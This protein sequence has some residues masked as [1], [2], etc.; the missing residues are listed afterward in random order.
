MAA[1]AAAAT[2]GAGPFSAIMGGFGLLSSFFGA[3]SARKKQERFIK[4]MMADRAA[5]IAEAKGEYD[6]SRRGLQAENRGAMLAAIKGVPA[7]LGASLM[8]GSTAANAMRSI[9]ADAQRRSAEIGRQTAAGKADLAML[10]PYDIVDP[11]TMGQSRG[12]EMQALSG[13]LSGFGQLAG[14]LL[15]RP[16]DPYHGGTVTGYGGQQYKTGFNEGTNSYMSMPTSGVMPGQLGSM[17]WAPGKTLS[18]TLG[19]FDSSG[20][21]PRFL[22]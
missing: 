7:S 16:S 18:P 5:R 13:V 3:R 2:A 14:G 19:G 22:G 12:A 9:Y 6:K 4:K 20:Y 8:Q 11:S 21:G 15:S 10:S 1:E 17:A